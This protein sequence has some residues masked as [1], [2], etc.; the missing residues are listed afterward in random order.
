MAAAL[1][2]AAGPAQWWLDSAPSAR[3]A[4]LAGLVVL[5]AGVYFVL[6]ILLGFRPRDF[7]RRASP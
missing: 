6:L 3:V 2:W 4:R 7:A 1:A 5:G